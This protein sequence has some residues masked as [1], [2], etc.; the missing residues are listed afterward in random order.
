MV[1]TAKMV[2]NKIFRIEKKKL[3]ETNLFVTSSTDEG[4]REHNK[5]T[6][7]MLEVSQV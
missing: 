3:R 6:S 4:I 5:Q 2:E 1:R 7:W